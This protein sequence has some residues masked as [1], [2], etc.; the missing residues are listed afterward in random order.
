MGN[1]WEV[2][3]S[4]LHLTLELPFCSGQIVIC[5]DPQAK[6][7]KALLQCVHSLYIP[8]KVRVFQPGPRPS[9]SLHHPLLWRPGSRKPPWAPP[10][11]QSPPGDRLLCCSHRC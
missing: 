6:D 5:G 2:W 11:S 1:P 9:T 7:T 10:V 4:S 3:A 8:N